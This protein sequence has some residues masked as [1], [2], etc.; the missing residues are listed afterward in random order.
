MS[1]S[2]TTNELSHYPHVPQWYR[3]SRNI[4]I[5]DQ[6]V[7]KDV[8][9]ITPIYF[10]IITDIN[11]SALA[12]AFSQQ[13]YLVQDLAAANHLAQQLYETAEGHPNRSII[14]TGETNILT[15]VYADSEEVIN[16]GS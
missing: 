5:A 10:G 2:V 16:V 8:I 1:A 14:I 3:L 9:R 13:Q 4:T 11:D 12:A 6:E 7:I 15:A